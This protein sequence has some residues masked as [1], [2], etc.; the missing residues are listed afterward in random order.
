M[1]FEESLETKPDKFK[2]LTANDFKLY[3][4]DGK[5]LDNNKTLWDGSKFKNNDKMEFYRFVLDLK[6]I[7]V[8]KLLG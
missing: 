1:I 6:N 8:L 7:I 5:E 3:T 4:L 2:S